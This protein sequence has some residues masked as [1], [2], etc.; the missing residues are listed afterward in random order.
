MAS[1]SVSVQEGKQGQL[2]KDEGDAIPNPSEKCD[3][4]DNDGDGL[5]DEGLRCDYPL[6]LTVAVDDALDAFIDGALVGNDTGTPAGAWR[7]ELTYTVNVPAGI[8]HLAVAAW[9]IYGAQAG[10]R[11]AVSVNGAYDPALSTGVGAWRVTATD[12]TTTF[13]AAWTTGAASGAMFPDSGFVAPS[14]AWSVTDHSDLIAASSQWVWVERYNHPADN[15][16]NWYYVSANVCPAALTQSE[17]CDGIDNNG[18][19]VIDEGYPDSDGDGYADCIDKETCDGKDNDGDGLIDEGFSD[20]DGDGVTDCMECEVCDGLDNDGDGQI[21]ENFPDTDGDGIKDCMDKEKCDGADNNGNGVVD[22]GYPDTDGDGIKDC[23]DRETCDGVDND[24]DGLVDEG[25]PDSDGDGIADCIDT[26]NEKCDC[27]DNDGDGQVDEGLR[28]TYPVSTQITVDDEYQ[29][30]YDGALAGTDSNWQSIE[31]HTTMMSPGLHYAAVEGGDTSTTQMGFL[32]A[33]SINGVIQPALRTGQGR[34]FG[35]YIAPTSSTWTT[36]PG[37]SQG[38]V[39]DAAYLT[40]SSCNSL[41]G[42]YWPSALLSTGAQWVWIKNCTDVRANP[43]NYYVMEFQVCPAAL[44]RGDEKC[45]GVDND[46]DGLIDEGYADW[47]LNGVADCLEDL[48]DPN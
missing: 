33:T 35:T 23:I 42:T 7:N 9:D 47:N 32:A 46:G 8:H 28:C 19:G 48:A 15:P 12:P 25:Y 43:D 44:P 22:E 41:W 14:T 36:T 40:S 21:D 10:F 16:Q 39:A 17:P 13:G 6:A 30:Y 24:G 4:I 1:E 29:L 31:T 26:N 18:D 5:V 3:C 20:A 38:M 2:Q 37:A 11:G 45:D 27:L 34:W